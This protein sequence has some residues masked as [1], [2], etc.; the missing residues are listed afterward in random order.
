MCHDC[1]SWKSC[2]MTWFLEIWDL[3]CASKVSGRETWLIHLCAM[4][5][6][7]VC[8]DLIS[9]LEIC[10]TRW[11]YKDDRHDS[12]I[13]VPWLMC[14]CVMTWFLEIC[15]AHRRYQELRH[16]SF[17]CVLW[18]ILSCVMTW[19]L[20]IC[21]A[22]RRYQEER[23]DSFICVLWRMCTCVRTWLLEICSTR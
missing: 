6:M 2:V 21:S 15:S 11:R 16:D 13:C 14:T 18:L 1:I 9:F 8:H 4:T 3:L 23:H 20:E 19:Y 7:S 17:I 12:F 10:S 5:Y 22:H